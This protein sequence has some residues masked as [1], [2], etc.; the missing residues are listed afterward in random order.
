MFLDKIEQ[1]N[2]LLRVQGARAVQKIEIANRPTLYGYKPQHVIDAVNQIFGP[3][4]WLYKVHDTEL[5]CSGEGDREGQ[6]VASVE[7]FLR[8]SDDAE[9]ISH[10]IQ[11]GQS[12]IVHGNVGDAK[13]GAVTSAVCKGLA[14]FSI[15]NMAYRG[16][17]ASV[18]EG[19]KIGD[20]SLVQKQDA[21]TP[22][23]PVKTGLPV[24]PH[25]YYDTTPEGTIIASGDTYKHKNR[26][27][28]MGFVWLPELKAWGLQKAA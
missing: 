7:V 22:P 9:F 25:V 27:K 14:T 1:V 10:G 23:A 6:V 5:F 17:L 13:K 11:F 8:T 26:L 18:Y 24:L 2:A 19:K 12:T 4:N 20:L 16:E 15:G 28:S 21:K 3:Q